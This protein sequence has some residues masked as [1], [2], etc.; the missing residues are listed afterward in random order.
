MKL[1]K[2]VMA[3]LAFVSCQPAT[4]RG[5]VQ[6]TQA[7]KPVV[8]T[9]LMFSGENFGKAEEAINLYVSLFENSE[10]QMLRLFQEEDQPSGMEGTVRE[11]HFTIAGSPFMAFDSYVDHPF[12]FTP[13]MSIFVVLTDEEQLVRAW[14]ELAKGGLEPMPLGDYDIGRMFGWV[15]DRYGVSWQLKL[16]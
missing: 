15:Q 5:D 6:H 14:S 13:S 4:D 7:G 12:S 10:I 2:T 11:A 9:F 8:R 16:E 3:F 1:L